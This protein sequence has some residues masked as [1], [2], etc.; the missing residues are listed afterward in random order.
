MQV[1]IRAHDME[2]K[3]IEPI[4]QG[5]YDAGADGAQLVCYKSFADI[6]KAPAGITE[7]RAKEIGEAFKKAGLSLAMLGASFNPVH[8]DAEKVET[9]MSIFRDYIK[10]G[11]RLGCHVIGS[12]TG[13]YN[14]EPWIYHPKNR[15]EE[16]LGE[17]AE[18]FRNLCDFASDYDAVICMEGASAHVCYD[19]ETLDRATRLVGRNNLKIVF[20]LYNFLDSGNCREYLSILAKGLTVFAER[21]HCFHIKDCIFTEAGPKQCA[22]GKGDLDFG[23]IIPMIKMFDEDAVLILEGTKKGDIKASVEFLKQKWQEA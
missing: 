14:D 12:E 17:V 19:I 23:C 8:S 16:A 7:E 9:D 21:I 4:I 2:V 3:G 15:T 10:A 20:D 22:V 6:E 11:N 5:L 18:R 13:S 1:C